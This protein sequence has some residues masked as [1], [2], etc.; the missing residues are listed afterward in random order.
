MICEHM[1]WTYQEYMQQPKHFIEILLDKIN[2][3]NTNNKIKPNG[4]K[5][6]S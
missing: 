6:N 4:N 2:I 5:A 3:D 1:H